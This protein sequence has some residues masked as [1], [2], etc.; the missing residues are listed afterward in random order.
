[1]PALAQGGSH[2]KGSGSGRQHLFGV[3]KSSLQPCQ[4]LQ[5]KGPGGGP[6]LDSTGKPHLLLV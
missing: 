3:Q 2:G 6:D 5:L 4:H 1:M